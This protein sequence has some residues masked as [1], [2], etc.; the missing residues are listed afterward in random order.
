M[1]TSFHHSGG[2]SMPDGA[3]MAEIARIAYAEAGIV[4]AP[5]KTSMVQ[6]R[7][8]K[9]LRALDLPDYDS[10]LVLV[11]SEAGQDERRRMI[12]ALTTNVS[13]FFRESHHFDTL[14]NEVLPP[15]VAKI[16]AGGR[17]RLWSAGCSNG[18]E[19]W[20]MAMTVLE[21]MPD[22]PEHDLR[23]LAT[24]ID[25]LVVEKGRSATYDAQMVAGVDPAL[26]KRFFEAA[27]GQHQLI[28][29]AQS[30]VSFHELNLHAPWPMRGPFDVIFCRN[31]V[32]YFDA[33]T[34]DR[35]WHRFAEVLAPGGWLMVGHSER[36]P[37]APASRF[38]TAG[39]TTYRL[40]PLAGNR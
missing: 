4:I 10:Y 5:G 24:D 20:S 6:S 3:Q 37:V 29:A 16:R 32:I 30:L 9:R 19:A 36:V 21:L 15:L 27:G 40:P 25:P 8:A 35:L 13:H 1:T 7:L 22:A 23:I 38:V 33:E 2:A 26:R 14:R 18:Q 31:V 17:A 11:N 39:I 34:Q 12:S 28:A